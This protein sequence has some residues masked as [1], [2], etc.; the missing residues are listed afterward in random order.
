MLLHENYLAM[1][2][3]EGLNGFLDRCMLCWCLQKNSDSEWGYDCKYPMYLLYRMCK[4]TIKY[5]IDKGITQLNLDLNFRP[6]RRAQ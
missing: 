3:N 1:P 6:L 5:S 2:E 4:H